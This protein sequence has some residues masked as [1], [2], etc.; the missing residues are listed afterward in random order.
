MPA[1]EHTLNSVRWRSRWLKQFVVEMYITIK[2]AMEFSLWFSE[3]SSD[4]A[5]EVIGS[6][7]RRPAFTIK[8][9]MQRLSWTCKGGNRDQQIDSAIWNFRAQKTL[10][11]PIFFEKVSPSRKTELNSIGQKSGGRHNFFGCKDRKSDDSVN[12]GQ[13]I[14]LLTKQT[15]AERC[16]STVLIMIQ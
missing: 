5:V 3:S 7:A 9:A 16:I 12:I 10:S 15:S 8:Y 14:F 13:P 11:E 6:H 4:K 1:T 2:I